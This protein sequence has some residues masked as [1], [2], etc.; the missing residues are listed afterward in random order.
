[1]PSRRKAMTT[2]TD[3]PDTPAGPEDEQEAAE[4]ATPEPA[5]DK[6]DAA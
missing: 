5:D 3:P 2:Y 6:E 4:G 1:M